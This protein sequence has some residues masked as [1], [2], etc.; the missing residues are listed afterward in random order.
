MGAGGPRP[1]DEPQSSSGTR[2]GA[3]KRAMS[4]L[5]AII[6]R[7]AETAARGRAGIAYLRHLV[8]VTA[9]ESRAEGF[10]AA[11]C[12]RPGSW[13]IAGADGC[14]EEGP[15]P[16]AGRPLAV[17]CGDI[18]NRA[19]I[20]GD[21]SLAGPASD[22]EL[23]A[24]AYGRWGAGLFDRLEGAF[25]LVVF[26]PARGRAIAGGDPDA[27]MQ[28]YTVRLGDDLLFATEAKA[29]LGDERFVVHL[30]EQAFANL[31]VLGHDFG[32]RTLFRGVEGLPHGCHYEIEDG[33][34]RV[35][36]HWDVTQALGENLRGDAYLERMDVAIRE[37]TEHALA[38]DGVL[39]PITGGVDSRM[40]AAAAPS[41]VRPLCFTFGTGA[42]PDCLR[43][44]QIAATR[45]FEHRL[46]DLEPDYLR[47]SA[48]STVW[49]TE[50][51]LNP[52][53]DITGGLMARMDEHRC[54][55]SGI[56]GDLGRRYYKNRLLLPDWTFIDADER[57]FE[58]RFL[59]GEPTYY[60]I[61]LAEARA[62]FGAR[63]DEYSAAGLADLGRELLTTRGLPAVDRLD[64]FSALEAT[65]R[66]ENPQLTAA[67]SWLDVRA[68]L[69]TRR[70]MEAVLAGATAERVDDLARLRLIR[71][72]DPAVARIPWG[73]TRLPLRPSETVLKAC[74]LVARLRRRAR[75]G[76][77][78]PAFPFPRLFDLA[79]R[80]HHLVYWHAEQHEE[81]LRGSSGAY[82]AEI[83]LSERTAARGLMRREGLVAL[84]DE[85]M[86][87]TDHSHVLAQALNIELWQRQFVDGERPVSP[88]ALP[89][90]GGD[91]GAAT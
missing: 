46:V 82:V 71:R 44:G 11:A 61:P 26:D 18:L 50:G 43:G 20:A 75:P 22:A 87:G 73:L 80:A 42:D 31:V 90:P 69:L 56:G 23:V 37:L 21:L 81:W 6:S 27:V 30:D 72:L 45:G 59:L 79:D 33:A 8:A 29:F 36:R 5:L 4:G 40:I 41:G 52:D 16:A 83:L 25:A 77:E 35:V 53:E 13:S 1:G 76:D 48:E 49:L 14:D 7:D 60:G 10:W 67:A 54:F 34:C 24:A 85:Q 86:R 47:D 91:T 28:V 62:I 39:F 84:L 3:A 55:V 89:H 9:G 64:L 58:R 15:A 38:G 65:P 17:V 32:G 88:D 68:P 57:E 70:W 74:R 66:A 19:A 2:R 12:G 63:A 51:R 78:G